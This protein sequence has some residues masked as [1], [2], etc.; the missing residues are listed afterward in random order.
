MAVLKVSFNR[1]HARHGK[2]E[3]G[4]SFRQDPPQRPVI[5]NEATNLEDHEVV[6]TSGRENFNS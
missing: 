3:S 6:G 5:E 1:N 4:K 2:P